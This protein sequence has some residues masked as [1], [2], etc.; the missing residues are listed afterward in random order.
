MNPFLEQYLA[1]TFDGYLD[2]PYFESY[3]DGFEDACEL[4][5]P[6]LNEALPHV[7]WVSVSYANKDKITKKL[8]EKM[9]EV[10]GGE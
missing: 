6:L 7:Q 3:E 10:L 2:K 8:L 5:L 9:L 4:L 1:D